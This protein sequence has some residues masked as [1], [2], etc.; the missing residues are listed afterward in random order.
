LGSSL[1]IRG[2]LLHE[3]EATMKHSVILL[4]L[5][6][7]ALIMQ[8]VSSIA[9]L[10]SLTSD[11]KYG[12]GGR[13]RTTTQ[14]D[15][16]DYMYST[17]PSSE[18]E[19]P[20]HLVFPGG[21]I[22]FY[23]QAGAVSY[24]REQGY[25]LTAVTAAGASAGALTATLAATGVDFYQATAL[26]LELAEKAGIWDRSGGLQGIWGPMIYDWLDELLPENAVERIENGRLS[27]LVTPL[28]K[29]GK[30]KIN[31]FKDRNDLIRCNM[32]S[33][34]LPWFLNGELTSNFRD[35]PCIDGSFL[36][37]GQDYLPEQKASSVLILDYNRDPTYEST[38]MLDFVTA[39]SPDGIWKMFEDGKKYARQMDEQGLLVSLPKVQTQRRRLNWPSLL[40]YNPL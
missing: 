35:Q 40:D 18:S 22:F 5:L 31:A 37:K 21:G 13:R 29:F 34:H 12:R 30:K 9:F 39:M 27:L 3:T 32:A 1:T 24:L 11:P 23:W 8:A 26:A 20:P 28:P 4:I 16:V 7:T 6:Q 14:V 33:I 36:S 38:K 2:P 19:S 10:P 25:N 15:A 17:T